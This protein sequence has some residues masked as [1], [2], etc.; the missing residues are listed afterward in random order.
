MSDPFLQ[1]MVL[2][3]A[4]CMAGFIAGAIWMLY[5]EPKGYTYAK[6]QDPAPQRPDLD[7]WDN[8][9]LYVPSLWERE[10]R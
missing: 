5:R 3:A 9:P 4:I 2:S 1:G 7:V 10:N 6:P 8:T